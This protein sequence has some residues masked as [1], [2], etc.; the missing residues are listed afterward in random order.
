MRM[1]APCRA[2]PGANSHRSGRRT[3]RSGLKYARLSLDTSRPLPIGADVVERAPDRGRVAVVA[4]EAQ[5]DVGVVDADGADLLPEGADA[6]RPGVAHG[7]LA[8]LRE[9]RIGLHDQR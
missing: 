9:S 4:M 2:E 3:P 6:G 5:V 7:V 1:A 8:S